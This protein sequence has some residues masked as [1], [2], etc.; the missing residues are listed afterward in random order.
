VR[1]RLGDMCGE[2]RDG[3]RG[4]AALA[5]VRGD[6]RAVTLQEDALG[7]APGG[8]LGWLWTGDT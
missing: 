2:V 4:E 8:W 1:Q 6:G 7:E 3:V 5:E